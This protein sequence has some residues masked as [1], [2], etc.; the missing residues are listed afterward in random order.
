MVQ[1]ED[2]GRAGNNFGHLMAKYAAKNFGVKLLDNGNNS[3]ETILDGQKVVIKS[4]HKSNNRIGI[5]HNVLDRVDNVIAILEDKTSPVNG[6][7]KYSIYKIDSKWF[8]SE[9]KPDYKRDNVGHL[10]GGKIRKY[11]PKIGV[12]SCDF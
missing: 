1:D 5:P 10:G 6:I 8:K 4:A 11:G 2:S 9:M 3:N 7:H 12:L